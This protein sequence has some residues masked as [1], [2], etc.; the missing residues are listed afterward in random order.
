MTYKYVGLTLVEE[1]VVRLRG[2][3]KTL[4]IYHE[5]MS[6]SMPRRN[7]LVEFLS[8]LLLPPPNFLAI[9]DARPAATLLLFSFNICSDGL[10]I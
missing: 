10:R 5:L 7:G 8:L 1:G 9:S 6:Y 4:V 3:R 2:L